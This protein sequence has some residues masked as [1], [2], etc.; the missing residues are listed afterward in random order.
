MTRL[1]VLVPGQSN[2]ETGPA[3]AAAALD[4]SR[5]EPELCRADR[6]DV[7]PRTAPDDDDV[8]ALGH[9][10]NDP[11]PLPTGEKR[12]SAAEKLPLKTE[13]VGKISDL[14]MIWPSSPAAEFSSDFAVGRGLAAE[15]ATRP[16]AC[17]FSIESHP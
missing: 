11:I 2:V 4:A 12:L 13:K 16:F 14:G 7:S 17:V 8:V 1:F 9:G 5:L 10:A 3:E 15:F 6:R